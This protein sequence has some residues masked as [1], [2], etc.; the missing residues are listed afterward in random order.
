MNKKK[1]IFIILITNLIVVNWSTSALAYIDPGS[2]SAIITAILGFFA[3]AGFTINKYIYKIK[4]FF[5]KKEI[6]DDLE[7]K[8][9]KK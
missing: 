3:A 6:K 7:K 5:S 9:D 8:F 1:K 2:T 4:K